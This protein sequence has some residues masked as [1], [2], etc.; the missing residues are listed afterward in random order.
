L[1]LKKVG[2]AYQLSKPGRKAVIC[3]SVHRVEPDDDYL[4]R[5]SAFECHKGES[6]RQG[7][8]TA[9]APQFV[10]RDQAVDL[11]PYCDAK[12]NE[13]CEFIFHL[14]SPEAMLY[15]LGEVVRADHNSGGKL[16]VRIR[17]R[18]PNPDEES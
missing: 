1:E 9:V 7:I 16:Q 12:S 2:D 17:L 10:G 11:R 15:Y 8:S 5:S 4:P 3:L 18:K 6:S 13:Y 14:R